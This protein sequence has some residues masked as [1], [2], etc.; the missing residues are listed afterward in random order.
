MRLRQLGSQQSITWMAPPEVHQSIL[1]LQSKAPGDPIDSH[2]VILWLLKQT[3][4]GIEQ[5]QPLY[6]SQGVDFCRRTEAALTSKEFLVDEMQRRAY[7][8][9]LRCAEQQTLEELYGPK[10]HAKTATKHKITNMRI[11]EFM[12]E[13]QTRRKGFQDFGN[14]VHGSVL[15]EVEQEREVAFEVEAVRQVQKPVH[16][17]PLRFPGL[18]EGILQFVKT[19]WLEW[20]GIGWE[21]AHTIFGQTDLGRK[22]GIRETRLRSKLFVSKEFMR[23][24][25]YPGGR[26]NDDFLVSDCCFEKRESSLEYAADY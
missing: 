2:D 12:S 11:K 16:Y 23:T 26:P 24:V 22:L 18:D 10:S 19:G 4:V 8:Q 7:L 9:V 6:F 13:L 20:D 15:Q 1:D 3:C 21:P 17:K 14:A 25:V 5:L